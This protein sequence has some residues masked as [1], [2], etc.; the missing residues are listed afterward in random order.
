MQNKQFLCLLAIVEVSLVHRCFSGV[1]P[2]PHYTDP[3]FIA[4]MLDQHNWYRARAQPYASNM[5]YMSWDKRLAKL[6]SIWVEECIFRPNAHIKDPEMAHPEFKSIGEI[7]W[8]G[9]GYAKINPVAAWHSQEAFYDLTTNTCT[10]NCD[11]Y[12]QLMWADSYKLG[13]AAH[14]CPG[15]E[16]YE[17]GKTGII[18]VCHYGPKGNIRGRKPF[19][20]G[21]ACSLCK[22]EKCLENMCRNEERDKVK[23]NEDWSPSS[24]PGLSYDL[25]CITISVFGPLLML[26]SYRTDYF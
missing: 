6:A 10:K 12:R 22:N 23:D 17:V 15:I 19:I 14:W 1:D 9:Q 26:L 2:V 11:H 3:S 4:K 21:E 25:Q 16:A 18:Y 13:C 20:E 7:F 24:G 8:V 5:L